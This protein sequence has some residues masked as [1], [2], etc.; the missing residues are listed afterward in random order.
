MQDWMAERVGI[1]PYRLMRSNAEFDTF[2][3]ILTSSRIYLT[4]LQTTTCV[5]CTCG[6][7]S[8]LQITL[9]W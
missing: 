1:S 3:Y 7:R 5:A 6:L 2:C 9:K 4:Y 8:K